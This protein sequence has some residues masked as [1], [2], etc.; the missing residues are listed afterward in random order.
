VRAYIAGALP[1]SLPPPPLS[2]VDPLVPGH[3]LETVDAV[4]D[5]VSFTVSTTRLITL[6]F[7]GAAAF[8]A[9]AFFAGAFLGGAFLAGA[10]LAG[11][12]FAAFFGAGRLA[13][14]FPARRAEVFFAAFLAGFFAAFFAFFEDLPEGFFFEGFLAAMRFLLLKTRRA[15]FVAIALHDGI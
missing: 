4:L 10:F 6:G 5:V 3:R 12:F 2:P 15:D 13:A 11:A 7:F 9:G 1:P 14:F 8:F